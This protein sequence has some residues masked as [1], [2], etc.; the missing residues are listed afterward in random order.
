[1]VQ[2]VEARAAHSF[3]SLVGKK[4]NREGLMRLKLLPAAALKGK[5]I[6]LLILKLLISISPTKRKRFMKITEI[7]TW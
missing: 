2:E 7:S 3:R 6:S 4:T 5:C 1:M